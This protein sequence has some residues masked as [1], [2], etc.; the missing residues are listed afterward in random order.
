MPISKLKIKDWRETEKSKEITNFPKS[1]DN[2]KISL[3]NSQY[4]QF[5]DFKYAQDLK[6]NYPTIWRRA[7]TG[8]NPPTSLLEMMHLTDGQ[9]TKKVIEVQQFF[10]KKKRTFYESS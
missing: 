8:E 4:K 5:P 9:N 6:D 3:T 1:G 10:F 2:Q 7:G